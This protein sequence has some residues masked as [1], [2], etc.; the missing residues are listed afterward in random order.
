MAGDAK[1]IVPGFNGG[2]PVRLLEFNIS[3]ALRRADG[4]RT[5]MV[6][7]WAGHFDLESVS[8]AQELHEHLEHPFE[9]GQSAVS[10]II[11]NASGASFRFD[12]VAVSYRGGVRFT[13]SAF[14]R[15][16]TGR[17]R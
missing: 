10:E 14:S 4:A 3:T 16:P 13:F 9:V 17:G 6:A 2:N 5:G 8:V 11:L 12:G 1:L 15:T 7:N